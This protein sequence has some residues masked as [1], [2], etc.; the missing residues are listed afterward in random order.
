VPRTKGVVR[1]DVFNLYSGELD[2]SRDREGWRVTGA[3]VGEH[4]GGELIGAGLYEVEPGSKLWPYHTHHANEEWLLVVRGR[5]ALRTPEGDRQ[6]D[7]GDVV[8]FPRGQAGAHQ[9]WNGTDSSIRVLMLSTKIAPEIV[10]YLDTGKVGAS[11]VAG[12]R[13]MFG[14]PGPELDYWEGEE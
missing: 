8:C 11:N 2:D 4:I 1:D 3:T 14:R 13:I 6:L 9:V 7:E 12:E 5:P 10:E